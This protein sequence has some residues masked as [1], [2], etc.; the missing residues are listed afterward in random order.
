MKNHCITLLLL[1]F[2]LFTGVAQKKKRTAKDSTA[3]E[4]NLKLSVL[5]VLYYLPETGLGYGA[6]GLSTFRLKGED[7]NARPSSAQ[8]ALTYTTKN[9]LLLFAP[10]EIYWGKEKW[11]LLGE[12]GYF[13]YFYNFY[14]LGVNSLEE[15][16][17]NYDVV[18]PRVRVTVLRE[19]FKDFSIGLGYELDSYS[20]VKIDDG[21]ILAA[22]DVIGKGG[23][24]VSNLGIVAFYDSRDNIFFPTK[25]FFVS[26]SVFSSAGF[27]GSSFDYSKFA[28][29]A[30]FYQ[31]L[32]GKH[33]LATNIF[34]GHNG[35]GSPFF[36]LNYI[37][38]KRTR[39]FSDRRFIDRTE[40]SLVAEYRFPISGRFGGVL[41]GSTGTVSPEIGDVFSSSYKNAAGAG[42]RYVINKKEG[43][44][45]RMD[46]GITNEGGNFYFTINEA[47]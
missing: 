27:L 26:G 11:R 35:K 17:E 6:I 12:L 19:L 24:T 13:K 36:D 22:S 7:K 47:F 45:I 4:K 42:I 2:C 32:K 21:G 46:Y 9:Q 18:F 44:R 14:G 15:N 10:Y 39:G 33:V 16:L 23:G 31:K 38:S 29:D 20:N 28:V 43:V 5:P 25:G 30:R 1:F 37:G 34:L 41:F 40:L 3:T 8:L